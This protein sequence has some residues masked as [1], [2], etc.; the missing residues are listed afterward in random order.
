ME[1]KVFSY[2]ETLLAGVKAS[3]LENIEAAAKLFAEALFL[4]KI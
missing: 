1:N 2:V 3:E 4:R